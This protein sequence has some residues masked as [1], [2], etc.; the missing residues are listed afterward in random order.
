MVWYDE[1]AD[2]RRKNAAKMEEADRKRACLSPV[3]YSTRLTRLD[4]LDRPTSAFFLPSHHVKEVSDPQRPGLTCADCGRFL[5]GQHSCD[6]ARALCRRFSGV[7]AIGTL[8]ALL[9]VASPSFLSHFIVPPF[10]CML[11]W[12][13]HPFQLQTNP[14]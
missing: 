12:L 4:S 3:F 5:R 11:L 1:S 14:R 8:S 7:P 10:Y 2:T 9:F 6:F 13:A